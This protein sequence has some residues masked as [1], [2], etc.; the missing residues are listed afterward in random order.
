MSKPKAI[1]WEKLC[2]NAKLGPSFYLLV[3]FFMMLNLTFNVYQ[4]SIMWLILARVLFLKLG[5]RAAG[6][7]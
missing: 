2:K 5:D 1:E 4:V 3:H 6:W 7:T